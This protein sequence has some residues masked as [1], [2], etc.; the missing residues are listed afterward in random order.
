MLTLRAWGV[1]TLPLRGR[2]CSRRALWNLAPAYW[3]VVGS[4]S[5]G[6]GGCNSTKD[7]SLPRCYSKQPTLYALPT[8]LRRGRQNISRVRNIREI[9]TSSHMERLTFST[10]LRSW[11]FC[12]N[13][14]R[15]G[16][17][18][19]SSHRHRRDRFH[20]LHRVHPSRHHLRFLGYC[21][22]FLSPFSDLRLAQ[23]QSFTSR[24]PARLTRSP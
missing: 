6:G 21:A 19:F 13:L 1:C 12:V 7:W 17:Y 20:L 22:G 8:V 18:Y 2:W 15:A 11:R 4:C 10:D 14:Q 5:R 23:Y 16:H 3:V 9:I 24:L